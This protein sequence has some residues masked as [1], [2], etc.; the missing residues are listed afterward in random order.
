METVYMLRREPGNWT[1]GFEFV[2]PL[3]KVLQA[4][5]AAGTATDNELSVLKESQAVEIWHLVKKR[6]PD[7]LGMSLGAFV[8]SPKM[9]E[10]LDTN[11]PDV[12]RYF[13]IQIK[14]PRPENGTTEHGTHWLLFPPPRIDCL[15]FELTIFTKDAEGTAWS[16]DRTDSNDYGLGAWGNGTRKDE[17]RPPKRC[18]LD[19]SALEGRHLWRVATGK[20]AAYSEYACSPDFWDF[21]NQ[22]KMMGWEID[23]TCEVI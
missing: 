1:G 11:E 4:R 7:V 15:N 22:N 13:P 16:R 17:S 20:S 5:L 8:I 3:D 9:R 21:Y 10:F 12:H 14:T 2:P 6:V 23:T 19:G 18:V